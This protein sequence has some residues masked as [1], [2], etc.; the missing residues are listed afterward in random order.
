[1]LKPLHNTVNRGSTDS[2]WLKQRLDNLAKT[3]ISFEVDRLRRRGW[4]ACQLIPD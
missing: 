2:D 3:T 4:F 1:M